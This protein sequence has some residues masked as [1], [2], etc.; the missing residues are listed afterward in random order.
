MFGGRFVTETTSFE[1]NVQAKVFVMQERV[2]AIRANAQARL[3]EE[4]LIDFKIQAL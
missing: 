4:Q 1:T 3:R 2:D